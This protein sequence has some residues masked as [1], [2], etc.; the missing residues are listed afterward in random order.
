MGHNKELKVNKMTSCVWRGK[1]IG[2][3]AIIHSLIKTAR[4]QQQPVWDEISACA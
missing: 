4:L 2:T 1:E 3:F